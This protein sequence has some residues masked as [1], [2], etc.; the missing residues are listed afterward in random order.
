MLLQACGVRLSLGV[1]GGS[2]MCCT[3]VQVR[4]RHRGAV[5]H[6]AARA[7]AVRS[8]VCRSE[9]TGAMDCVRGAQV[10]E[11]S[12]LCIQLFLVCQAL[13]H[14]GAWVAGAASLGATL[15]MGRGRRA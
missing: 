13:A 15:T 11:R 12:P 4:D 5:C 2:R 8:T 10:G 1:R 3:S 6:T 9:L 7:C 14:S